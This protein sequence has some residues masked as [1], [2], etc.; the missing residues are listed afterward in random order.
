MA[1]TKVTSNVLAQDTAI[2]NIAEG[3]SGALGFRNKIINGDMRI[4]QR[5][6]GSAATSNITGTRL[7][8]ADRFFVA[9]QS[10]NPFLITAQRI[11]D[12]SNPQFVNYFRTTTTTATN[13]TGTAAELGQYVIQH[14]IEGN[15]IRNF[16]FGTPQAKTLILTFW[17]RS[18]YTGTYQINCVNGPG[19]FGRLCV[20]TYQ[21]NTANTWE[22]KTITI[23][24]DTQEFSSWLTNNDIGLA[25]S[26]G[27]GVSDT[28]FT[29]GGFGTNSWNTRN[30]TTNP[31]PDISINNTS[32]KLHNKAGAYF[33]LTGVQLEEG[34]VATPFEQRPIGTE[35]ALCQRYFQY[36]DAYSLGAYPVLGGAS[37][38]ANVYFPVVMRKPPELS[39]GTVVLVT[40]GGAPEYYFTNTTNRSTWL[41]SS[42]NGQTAPGGFGANTKNNKAEAEL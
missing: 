13:Y 29:S 33:D 32:Q 6:S 4:D 9:L 20:S 18:N 15:D 5:Y 34:S 3:T 24:G 14:R 8:M 39:F 41:I 11:T 1:T 27:L 30:I 23:P 2:K 21:I 38:V 37:A 16:N 26:W 42:Q 12:N 7:Y 22:K 25:I 31:R 19:P 28:F 17:V 36:F 10:A 35:L 40:N